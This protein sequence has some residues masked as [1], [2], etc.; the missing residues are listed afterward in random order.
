[1][2][3]LADQG[4]CRAL[5]LS[6]RKSELARVRGSVRARL[7]EL[8]AQAKVRMLLSTEV[9]AISEHHVMLRSHRGVEQLDNDHVVV[10][11]GGTAPSQLLHSIGIELVEKRGEA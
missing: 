2:I 3:A 4:R 5:G 11:I 10:Q 7:D 6:Y 8:V 9:A 1:V